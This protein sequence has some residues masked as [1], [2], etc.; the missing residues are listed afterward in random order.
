MSIVET[1]QGLTREELLAQADSNPRQAVE[2][3]LVQA[4]RE[5]RAL[6]I[7]D[8][9]TFG[10]AGMH[11]STMAG[12]WRM[13]KLYSRTGLVPDHFKNK[14]EDCC[15]ALQMAMRCQV[16]PLM[17]MQAC[18]MVHGRPGVEAKFAIALCNRAQ[19]FKD[20]IKFKLE[21][22][23]D[24]RRCTAYAHDKET[25]ERLE[26]TVTMEMAK[27]EG[28]TTKTGSKWKTMPDL[29]LQYRSSMF[30]IRL[31]CPEVLMGM[32]SVEELDDS[33][34]SEIAVTSR[35]V[36]R[37]AELTDR[38]AAPANGNGNGQHAET[39][40]PTVDAEEVR[41]PGDD[42]DEPTE[43][44]VFDLAAVAVELEKCPTDVACRQIYNRLCGPESELD[45]QQR[46]DVAKLVIERREA[47]KQAKSGAKQGE[48]LDKGSPSAVNA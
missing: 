43:G 28:W 29:M 10:P 38:L 44:D 4:E 30:L 16:D 5:V 33:A 21:G 2:L 3:A 39:T 41:E 23:G 18:Y 47:L 31:T 14:P 26:Q 27:A 37:L 36:N 34:S 1:T 40:V 6:K 9:I 22:T 48:L 45:Q 11:C 7:D 24:G 42:G 35:P 8:E 19:V 20:R 32:Q 15:I 46:D 12:L 25:G 17:F 13:A